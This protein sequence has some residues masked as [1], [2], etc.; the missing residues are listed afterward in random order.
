MKVLGVFRKSMLGFFFKCLLKAIR[1]DGN[2]HLTLNCVDATLV[3][4]WAFQGPALCLS[5]SRAD[6][7]DRT[8]DKRTT[9]FEVWNRGRVLWN[10]FDIFEQRRL[11]QKMDT[12][13]IG[14]KGN[15]SCDISTSLPFIHRWPFDSSESTLD[16]T[17]AM[18]E[19]GIRCVDRLNGKTDWSAL[20]H[21]N[22]I[23]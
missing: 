12:T 6:T 7:D 15:R 13:S 20:C 11:K 1:F 3:E 2:V 17:K 8:G 18:D 14:K 4:F 9:E 5:V 22:D 10:P 16:A 21:K 23:V 19:W